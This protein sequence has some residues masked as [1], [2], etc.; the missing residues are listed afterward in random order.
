MRLDLDHAGSASN[1]LRRIHL[2]H[3]SVAVSWQSLVTEHVRTSGQRRNDSKRGEIRQQKSNRCHR[4][5]RSAMSTAS[6]FLSMLFATKRCK[7]TA[8]LA[9]NCD[10]LGVGTLT[11]LLSRTIIAVSGYIRLPMSD[12]NRLF[13]LQSGRVAFLKSFGRR[14]AYES[15]GG[16]NPRAP[17]DELWG[18]R[19]LAGWSGG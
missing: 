5:V 9:I 14:Q 15:L 19:I 2:N 6:N 4:F 13:S 7:L 8:R 17:S 12:R 3:D 18:F 16:P 10:D 1:A 11:M